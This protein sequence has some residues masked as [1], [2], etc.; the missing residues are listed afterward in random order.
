MFCLAHAYMYVCRTLLKKV[1]TNRIFGA[2]R[3]FV[4]ITYTERWSI[5]GAHFSEDC[6]MRTFSGQDQAGVRRR[7]SLSLS[8]SITTSVSQAHILFLGIF[9]DTYDTLGKT[10]KRRMEEFLMYVR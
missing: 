4:Q 5:T 9:S 3:S 7:L 10:I 8:L 6:G 2:A 1:H